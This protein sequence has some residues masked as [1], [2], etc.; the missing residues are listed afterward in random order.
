MVLLQENYMQN[1]N[2][3]ICYRCH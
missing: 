1:G 3:S 2:K